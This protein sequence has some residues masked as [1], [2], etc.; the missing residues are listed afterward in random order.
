MN[1]I[2]QEKH[3][4][5]KLNEVCCETKGLTYVCVFV[6]ATIHRADGRWAG[7]HPWSFNPFMPRPSAVMLLS[8]PR[9]SRSLS[10]VSISEWREPDREQ[11]VKASRVCFQGKNLSFCCFHS[12]N[13]LSTPE[14]VFSSTYGDLSLKCCCDCREC[15]QKRNKHF[16]NIWIHVLSFLWCLWWLTF[17]FFFLWTFSCDI[18]AVFVSASFVCFRGPRWTESKVGLHFTSKL[19]DQSTADQWIYQLVVI[20][21]NSF[22]L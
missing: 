7:P 19:S 9:W 12:L 22:F 21:D 18:R 16:E 8:N 15:S 10:Q 17:F 2:Y 4:K 1:L 14:A 13:T 5:K 3:E 11:T 20:T 6:C